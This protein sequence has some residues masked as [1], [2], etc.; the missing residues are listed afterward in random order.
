[1]VKFL[2]LLFSITLFMYQVSADVIDFEDF[3]LRNG[4]INSI[5]NYKGFNWSDNWYYMNG[6]EYNYESGYKK[7]G[8]FWRLC[9]V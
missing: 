9:S 8:G 7:R 6:E 3:F 1:M 5:P 2:I 4:Q